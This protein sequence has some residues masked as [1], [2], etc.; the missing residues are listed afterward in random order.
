[1]LVE[2]V[3]ILFFI[4]NAVYRAEHRLTQSVTATLLF[5]N[6]ADSRGMRLNIINNVRYHSFF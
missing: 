1:M 3:V 6:N 2:A 5:L 4:Q